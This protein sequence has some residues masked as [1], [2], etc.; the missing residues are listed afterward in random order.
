MNK[1]KALMEKKP[2]TV[3]LISHLLLVLS[4]IC[5]VLYIC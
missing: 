2:T 4:A 3:Y 1:I 5:S